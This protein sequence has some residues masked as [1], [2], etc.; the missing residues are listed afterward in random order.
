MYIP[1]NLR[2]P[3]YEYALGKF[4][5]HPAHTNNEALE[6]WIRE[7][8]FEQY[9]LPENRMQQHSRKRNMLYTFHLPAINKEVV[10]KVSQTSPHYRWYRKLNLLLT[11][12]VKNYSLNA[13]YG[14]IALENIGVDSIKT[15]AYWTCKRQ[16]QSTKSYLLYEKIPASMSAYDLCRQLVEK[17]SN[18]GEIIHVLAKK[19]AATVRKIHNNDLRHGDPHAGN[20][21]LATPVT[22][23]EQLTTDAVEQFHFV[24]IDLDKIQFSEQE[25]PWLRRIRNLRCLR[26]FR[27][28]NIEGSKGLEYYLD[29]PPGLLDKAILHFWMRGGFNLYKWIKPSRKRV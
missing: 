21:L 7:L 22:F 23:I 24:L 17:N 2:Q 16:K 28:H 10:L 27:V 12:L 5:I 19:L 1:T 4:L 6:S 8:Q 15:L 20:F 18:A 29:N 3:L 14:S 26:R 11:N 9:E 25:K 13:Y